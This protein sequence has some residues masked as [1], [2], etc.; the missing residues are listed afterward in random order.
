[1]GEKI[2]ILDDDERILNQLKWALG[3]DYELLLFKH[4]KE[5]KEAFLS[6]DIPL[7]LLDLG[8][9]PHPQNPK[10]GLRLLE[11][12][13]LKKPMSKIIVVTG[14][15]EKGAALEAIEKGAYD[16][17]QKPIQL[18]ELRIIIKRAF[19]IYHLEQENLNLRGKELEDKGFCGI[20]GTSAQMLSLFSLIEKVAP[21]DSS[22][23]ITGETGTG[24]EMVARA[25]HRL[26][27]RSKNPFITVNCSAIPRELIESELF[28]HEKGAFTGASATRKGK[29][30][31]AHSGTIF[32]DEIGDMPME[33]Q[34][35]LLRVLQ[36][37]EIM[38]V[39]G[40]RVIPIDVR[41]LSA[42]NHNL[43][44]DIKAGSF[45]EDLYYRIRVVEINLPP[46]RERGEDIIL[47]ARHFLQK[48]A[49]KLNKDLKGF[50]AQA[51]SAMLSYAWPGNVRELQNRVERASILSSGP[52]VSEEHLE[53][54]GSDIPSLK[55]A[56]ERMEIDLIRK[57]LTKHRGNI[58]RAAAELDLKRSTL[59]DLMKKYG[60]EPPAE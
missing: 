21:T 6:Q 9:P 7:V 25:I 57:A 50:S 59:Y 17:Y 2:L 56:R 31:L 18:E 34:V 15:E 33:M 45:R 40:D 22:V 46:L 43:S 37:K 55:K 36:E 4:P 53:L 30:E 16:Y 27:P 8:L 14:Q 38:R 1:M 51:L 11:E 39:G 20:M 41:L 58:S 32:L 49:L 48:E 54:G 5:A 44:E 47:L 13:L 35:K 3:S 42:T 52:L 12:F 60:I 26:S 28:G 10:E 29:F 23:L 24:K 19:H